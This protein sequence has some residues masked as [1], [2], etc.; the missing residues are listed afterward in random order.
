[1]TRRLAETLVAAIIAGAVGCLP[2]QAQ[3]LAPKE[4]D[5][6]EAWY[7]RT[8][9]RTGNG[10]WGVAVGTMDGRVLWS[11]SPELALIPASTAKVFTT[12]FT[13]T[14]VGGDGRITTRVVGDG[15]LE[16]TSG[17]W[18]GSWALDLGGDWT[19]DRAGRSGP[20]LRELAR[21]LRARGVRQLEGPLVLTSPTGPAT[22]Q[23]PSV[24]SA[25][26]EG[27][28]YAPPVGPV[29][30]HENTISLTYRPG[31][32][33]G[34]PPT[35]V[36]AYPDGVE[37]LIRMNATTVSGGGG[38]LW[39]TPTADGGWTLNGSIGLY[40]RPLGFSAVA[41]DPSRLLAA[42]WASALERAG[43]RWVMPGGPIAQ[44][45]QAQSVLAQV[46][47]AT[48]D[49]VAVEVNRRSLN[50]GAELMLQWAAG[51]QTTGPAL[52]TDHVRRVVGP[53][54]RVSLV[55]GSGLSELNRISPMTQMLYLARYPQLPGN[56]RFPLLLPANGT[57]TLRRLR[58]GMGR[59]VVH[60]KTGTLDNVA[61]LAGY[62]GRP[63]GVLVISL[64]F[65]GRRIGPARTAEWELFRLLGAEGVDLRGALETQMGGST[66]PSDK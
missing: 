61:N 18:Q 4:L 27:Q 59:G 20:T 15:S 50:I 46:E 16:A 1:M 65:N 44:T 17:R 63:D 12:G 29:A 49:S 3:S 38:R 21:R 52:V 26:F 25:D 8:A 54:A 14:R 32:D 40:R 6:L 39:L 34:A 19:L 10:E 48:F 53:S 37:R 41:H 5:A 60:A 28:L 66:T 35:L 11:M 45:R 23:Y 42:V 47:S 31:R 36:T 9:E 2:V 58:G 22:S 43:I 64:M 30:L 56:E 57:G 7:R 33:T 13:R 55:D 51:S 62:L 24:W